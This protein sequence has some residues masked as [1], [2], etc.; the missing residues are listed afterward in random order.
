[1]L[2]ADKAGATNKRYARFPE[3]GSAI[4]ADGG[5][6]Q[7]AR[8][9]MGGYMAVG[10]ALGVGLG[11]AFDNVAIG[12]ALGAAAGAAWGGLVSRKPHD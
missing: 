11:A 12:I 2:W 1:L 5:D 4:A 9:T 3:H 10:M 7:G 8:M 6:F